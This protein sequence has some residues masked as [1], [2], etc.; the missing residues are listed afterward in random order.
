[1]NT[2]ETT[3][4]ILDS[5]QHRYQLP[6]WALLTELRLSTGYA[7]SQQRMDAIAFNCWPSKQH[8]RI[9]FEVKAS[10][11]DL[12]SDLRSFKWQGYLPFVHQF[13]FVLPRETKF[14]W[15]E[16]PDQVGV[17]RWNGEKIT[18]TVIHDA[19]ELTPDRGVIQRSDMG[20][21]L[22]AVRRAL[23]MPQQAGWPVS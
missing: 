15:D 4:A 3:A 11:A 17:I 22:S 19:P 14:T 9:G 16:L 1:M 2:R 23:Q 20:F 13:Y 7:G 12:L 5:L 8:E 21:Y 6:E 10:R 18:M